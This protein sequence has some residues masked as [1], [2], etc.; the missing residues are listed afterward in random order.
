MIFKDFTIA[1]GNYKK[2]RTL[3]TRSWKS[4]ILYVALFV[5]ICSIGI[6]II[7]TV[8]GGEKILDGLM[9]TLPE[10]TVTQDGLTISETFDFETE[11]I[12]VLATNE[13]QVDENDF[14]D[15]VFGVLLDSDN[16]YIK[17]SGRVLDFTYGEF[18]LSGN[19]Y[20]FSKK[21]IPSLKPY[22]L[23]ATLLSNIMMWGWLVSSYFISGLIIAAVGIIMT[24]FL[25]M[26]LNTS[27]MIKLALYAKTLPY[28]ITAVFAVFGVTMYSIISSVLS[29]VIL[30]LALREMRGDEIEQ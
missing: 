26:H 7:P 15:A 2:Y 24:M 6:V 12:K 3:S 14:G 28:M 9:Q 20:S 19:G 1:V 13:K 29:A 30:F 23:I 25:N 21:D 10:F 18:N 22:W 8:R 16:L 17:R 11:G 4:V 27:T 5:L